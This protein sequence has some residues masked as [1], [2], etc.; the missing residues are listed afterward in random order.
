MELGARQPARQLMP[1]LESIEGFGMR[2]RRFMLGITALAL[3][4]I[5][6]FFSWKRFKERGKDITWENYE[7]IHDG[8]TRS[9]VEA[10]FGVPAGDYRTRDPEPITFQTAG[11]E[12][13][14]RAWLGDEGYALIW[15]DESDEVCY[16]L[17]RVDPGHYA[18]ESL[19][20]RLVRLLPW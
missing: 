16:Q 4:G 7:R 13:T 5:A 6:G 3:L 8:M 15:F 12:G 17:F 18:N 14:L 2:T 10:I 1:G 20:E 19:F 9:Q 11:V